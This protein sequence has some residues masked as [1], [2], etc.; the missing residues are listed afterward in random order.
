MLLTVII[1]WQKNMYLWPM[2]NRII[3][4]FSSSSFFLFS[5]VFQ[6]FNYSHQHIMWTR[7]NDET[8]IVRL[9]RVTVTSYI[10]WGIHVARTESRLF[11]LLKAV[12]IPTTIKYLLFPDD[13]VFFRSSDEGEP[14][15]I[16]SWAALAAANSISKF[17]IVLSNVLHRT[18]SK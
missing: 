1:K 2:T 8:N 16:D 18:T 7:R 5:P 14:L 10:P 17:E 3:I 9:R 15:C 11:L 4:P 13:W 12:L 6:V